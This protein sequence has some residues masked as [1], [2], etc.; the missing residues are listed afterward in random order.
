MA[1][2]RHTSQTTLEMAGEIRTQL[3]RKAVSQVSLFRSRRALLPD[4]V[5]RLTRVPF[6]M[7]VV[8][9]TFVVFEQALQ[10]SG[11]V[12]IRLGPGDAAL[13]AAG[14]FVNARFTR[15]VRFVRVTFE[16]DGL[17]VGLERVTGP[18]AQKGKAPDHPA[19]LLGACWA[20][21][22]LAQPAAGLLQRL[23]SG[24]P[25]ASLPEGHKCAFS[26]LLWELVYRLEA[27]DMARSGKVNFTQMVLRY[28]QDQCHRPIRRGAVA[29]AFG[30]SAGYLGRAV[31]TET[32]QAFQDVLL[33]MR[34]DRARWL[35]GQ[36]GLTIEEVGLRSGFNSG[37]YFAQ[38]FRRAE[39]MSP[40]D[41][42]AHRG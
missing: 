8:D 20:K 41:W 13:F 14:S 36:G 28:M 15:P 12:K 39:G 2:P 3:K 16:P 24:E 25:G 23:L 7:W 6:L 4:F 40:R 21:G 42:R 35:L 32:G 5:D 17:F 37:N 26:A 22:S 33:G 29:E 1:L 11:P 10:K 27:A 34:L 19:S 38:A 9:G 31:K 30:V 18:V